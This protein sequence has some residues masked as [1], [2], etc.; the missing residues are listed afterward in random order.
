MTNSCSAA[1]SKR[2]QNQGTHHAL[3]YAR[4]QLNKEELMH[5]KQHYFSEDTPIDRELRVSF[6][7][8]V[9][10]NQD[11][12]TICRKSVRLSVDVLKTPQQMRRKL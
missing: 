12:V 3:S 5:I 9:L 7:Q 8:K 10:A 4:G 1:I 2:G 11:A 6:L